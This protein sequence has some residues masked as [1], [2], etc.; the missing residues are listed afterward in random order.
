MS[1]QIR[2]LGELQRVPEHGYS[3]AGVDALHHGKAAL[4]PVGDEFLELGVLLAV[5]RQLGLG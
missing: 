1:G 5:F 4:F 2:L 3:D